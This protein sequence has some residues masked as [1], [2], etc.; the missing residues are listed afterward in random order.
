MI[1]MITYSRNLKKD[2]MYNKSGT[3]NIRGRLRKK[4]KYHTR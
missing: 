2:R 4:E 3:L 1:R